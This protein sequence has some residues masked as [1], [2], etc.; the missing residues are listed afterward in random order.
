MCHLQHREMGLGFL[1]SGTQR[2]QRGWSGGEQRCEWFCSWKPRWFSPSGDFRV[3]AELREVPAQRA[4]PRCLWELGP[5]KIVAG[6][7]PKRCSCLSQGL[8]APGAVPGVWGWWDPASSPRLSTA[9][10]SGVLALDPLPGILSWLVSWN[11]T[12]FGLYLGSAANNP[13]S[14]GW[15]SWGLAP[16]GSSGRGSGARGLRPCPQH[17]PPALPLL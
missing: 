7:C 9:L 6:D 14:H 13:V 8:A 5:S 1:G 10:L 2:G 3:S 11:F 17:L 16:A 12:A 4:E 15:P